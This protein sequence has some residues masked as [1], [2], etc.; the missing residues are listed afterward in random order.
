[1]V[2]TGWKGFAAAVSFEEWGFRGGTYEA[3]S[4]DRYMQTVVA[5]AM[6]VLATVMRLSAA[7]LHDLYV[8]VKCSSGLKITSET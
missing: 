6:V 1:M 3:A 2:S 5:E 4:P 7:N 8:T